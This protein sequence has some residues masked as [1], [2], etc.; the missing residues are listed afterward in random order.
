MPA[1]TNYN[2]PMTIARVISIIQDMNPDANIGDYVHHVHGEN[3]ILVELTN[4]KIRVSRH[5]VEDVDH[6]YEVTD[7]SKWMLSTFEPNEQPKEVKI[8]DSFWI[9]LLKMLG[10]K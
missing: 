3:N 2:D 5:A 4:G 9:K 10:L 1:N 7:Y 6:A 8:K